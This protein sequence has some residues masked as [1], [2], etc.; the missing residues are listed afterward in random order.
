MALA[1][2]AEV[3]G[4]AAPTRRRALDGVRAVAAIGVVVY[5][6]F[7][8]LRML[9][10]TTIAAA[11]IENLGNFGVAVFFVLSG[12]L[13]FREFVKWILFDSERVA[14]PHYF[15]RRFLR[16]YPG[17]W[18]AVIGSLLIVGLENFK[19]DAVGIFTLLGRSFDDR[20]V[21]LGL[22]VAWTLM[23][24]V[25]FY[26]VLPIY[27]MLM[28]FIVRGCT[29]PIRRLR[30]VL[31]ALVVVGV[32][33]HVWI[34]VVV[35]PNPRDLRLRDNLPTYGGWFALGMA[36]AVAMTWRSAGRSLPRWL[37][38]LASRTWA[39]WTLASL[40]Y[41]VIVLQRHANANLAGNP[42]LT[43]TEFQIRVLFQGLAAL[44][45]AMPIVLGGEA[46]NA[47][48]ILGRRLVAWVGL[49]SYGVYLWHPAVIHFVTERW[50]FPNGYVGLVLLAT[51]V[52]VIV[53]PIAWLSYRLIE[54]PAL[55]LA[56]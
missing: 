15:E 18:V 34:A 16:I 5:H 22:G 28:F 49:V 40:A 53:V 12:F 56:R 36:L 2:V 45:F 52:V 21:F 39:C 14:L 55:R 43:V 47:S 4:P 50:S 30:R 35:G 37:V 31:I 46:T 19:G 54:R 8:R 25:L 3:A 41:L 6:C 11:F 10:K 20:N 33:A 38:E 1:E 24:E 29:D 51:G 17:Y 9:D 42:P 7:V 13:L 26:L 32:G 48:K 44:F 23:I 27:S